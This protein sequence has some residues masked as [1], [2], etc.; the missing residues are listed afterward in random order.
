MTNTETFSKVY[1]GLPGKRTKSLKKK[2]Q[3]C[4]IAEDNGVTCLRH[5]RKE[6]KSHILLIQPYLLSSIDCRQT[7][8]N[9]QGLRKY[10]SQEPLLSKLPENEIDWT[11]IDIGPGGEQ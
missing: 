11:D 6:N 2:R 10:C 8:I 4:F 3:Q 1:S 9:K 5:S 7:D